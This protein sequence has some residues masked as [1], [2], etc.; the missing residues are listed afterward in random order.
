MTK[1]EKDIILRALGSSVKRY[2]EQEE[3]LKEYMETNPNFPMTTQ[4]YHRA[5]G[6]YLAMLRLCKE[7]GLDWADF[8]EN[9][10]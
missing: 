9:S 6:E 2:R 8:I 7:L 3:L 10:I 4:I 1:K 5:Q